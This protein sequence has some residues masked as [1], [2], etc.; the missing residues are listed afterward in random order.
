VPDRTDS[1]DA[2]EALLGGPLSILDRPLTVTFFDNVKDN[3]LKQSK[4]TLPQLV[5]QAHETERA[6]KADI[7]MWKLARF[8]DNRNGGKAL[9]NDSNLLEI[10]GIEGDHDAGTMTVAAAKRCLEAAGLAG[11]IYTTPWP[12]S[13]HNLRHGIGFTNDFPGPLRGIPTVVPTFIFWLLAAKSGRMNSKT[14]A[15]SSR[16]AK[17]RPN[18][19]ACQPT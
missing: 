18:I 15:C 3:G 6:A 8:C 5:G 16:G 19:V 11:L 1:A 10:S 7:P 4:L 17:K 12:G 9:R 14:C 13:Y 2:F